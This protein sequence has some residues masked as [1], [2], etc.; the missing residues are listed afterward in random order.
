MRDPHP[1]LGP[2]LSLGPPLG[3]GIPLVVHPERKPRGLGRLGAESLEKGF[4]EGDR[5]QR[6]PEAAL[7]G[8]GG[9]GGR[10]KGGHGEEQP[11]HRLGAGGLGSAHLG[12]ERRPLRADTHTRPWSQHALTGWGGERRPFRRGLCQARNP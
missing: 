5:G 2:P 6:R 4:A 11:G 3:P 1:V 7:R 8:Y 12:P 9:R 10:G